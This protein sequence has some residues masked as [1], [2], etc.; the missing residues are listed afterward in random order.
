M[1]AGGG[2]QLLDHVRFGKGVRI[3]QQ[4]PVLRHA[5]GQPV[6]AGRKAQIGLAFHTLDPIGQIGRV[7]VLAGRRAVLQKPHPLRGHR[8]PLQRRDHLR[9]RDP[10]PVGDDEDRDGGRFAHTALRTASI[11]V[12]SRSP[13]T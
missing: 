1:A 4:K 8:L 10:A 2:H 13:S 9:D 5:A 3:D 7:D 12:C 11:T 6:I